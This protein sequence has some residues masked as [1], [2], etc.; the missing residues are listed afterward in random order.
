[1]YNLLKSHKFHIFFLMHVKVQPMKCRSSILC[2]DPNTYQYLV[3][4]SISSCKSWLHEGEFWQSSTY[5]FGFVVRGESPGCRLI[6]TASMLEWLRK[7]LPH[8][9]KGSSTE[10]WSRKTLRVVTARV[11][12]VLRRFL[13]S[14]FILN[15]WAEKLIPGKVSTSYGV[16]TCDRWHQVPG[17]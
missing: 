4:I 8:H 7:L 1:M 6:S 17:A 12:Y 11:V 15:K 2:A 14:P 3:N 13:T 16:R 10:R 9:S 5:G